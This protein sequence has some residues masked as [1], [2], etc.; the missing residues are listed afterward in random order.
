MSRD[1]TVRSG[2]TPGVRRSPLP[3][4]A[5][6]G[7]LA[8][9]G[10]GA[11]SAEDSGARDTLAAVSSDDSGDPGETGQGGVA[12]E[13]AQDAD[14]GESTAAGDA[15]AGR[16]PS[17]VPPLEEEEI[18]ALLLDEEELPLAPDSLVEEAGAD[19]FQEHIGVVGDTYVRAFGEDECARQMDSVNERLVGE[20]PQDGVIRQ[21]VRDVEGG[22][23]RLYLWMLSYQ[24]PVDSAQIWDDVLDACAGH[25]L[26]DGAD[27][28][29]FEAFAAGGFRG[30]TM[31]MGVGAEDDSVEMEGFSA[32]RDLGSNLMMISAVNIDAAT[33][34]EVVEAQSRKIDERLDLDL[35]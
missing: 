12:P 27:V 35:G 18:A 15:S 26:E 13:N 4:G 28:I 32:T 31:E 22:Q 20:A 17:A 21:V 5:L 9:T 29:D 16:D 30:L 19:Y 10:C 3:A 1:R 25:R 11:G 14:T 24:E 7:L 2:V 23:E 34:E 33:F 6:V 8:L